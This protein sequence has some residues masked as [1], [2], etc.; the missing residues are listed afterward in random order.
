MML[1]KTQAQLSQFLESV[2]V[3]KTLP[4]TL[5]SRIT[6]LSRIREEL[7]KL[8]KSNAARS[9]SLFIKKGVNELKTE[10]LE[11]ARPIGLVGHFGPGNFAINAAYS[12]VAGFICGN[13]NIVRV[14]RKASSEDIEIIEAISRILIEKKVR[15][16]FVMCEEADQTVKNISRVVDARVV[17]GSDEVIG[18]I[19]KMEVKARCR[20][21]LFASS[22]SLCL[23]NIDLFE[24]QNLSHQNYIINALANDLFLAD[25]APCTAPS[26]LVASSGRYSADIT[27]RKGMQILKKSEAAYNTREPSSLVLFNSQAAFLQEQ[28][29]EKGYQ[30]CSVKDSTLKVCRSSIIKDDKLLYRSLFIVPCSDVWVALSDLKNRPS[31]VTHYG[32]QEGITQ[33]GDVTGSYRVVDIGQAHAFNFNWDGIDLIASLSLWR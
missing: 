28:S 24:E 1:I 32:F 9:F 25:G 12:W 2:S 3:N 21:L 6:I 23:F 4:S 8:S 27:F 29:A 31:T 15:D 18:K 7:S 33:I 13:T 16:V 14:S 17:W 22:N 11:R 19:R 5:E 10:R 26:C 30:F 20:D